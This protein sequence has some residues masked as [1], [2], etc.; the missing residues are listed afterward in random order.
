MRKSNQCA[1]DP[2]EDRARRGARF[3]TRVQIALDR[4]PCAAPVH[5][6]RNAA[7]AAASGKSIG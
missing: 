2:T 7:N 4:L 5:Q 6:P 1:A 3:K